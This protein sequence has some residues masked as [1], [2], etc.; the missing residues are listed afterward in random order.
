[1][2]SYLACYTNLPLPLVSRATRTR[3][4]LSDQHPSCFA[5]MDPITA[6]GLVLSVAGLAG[7]VFTGC[8]QGLQVYGILIEETLTSYSR[9]SVHNNSQEPTGNV[10]VPQL[11]TANG[12][13]T[14]VCMER[15]IWTTG[16]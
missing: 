9:H 14:A 15:D 4:S 3:F 16:S 1:M 2:Q 13:A 5:N 11:E 12:T 6:A 10:Q 7:Q 8:I